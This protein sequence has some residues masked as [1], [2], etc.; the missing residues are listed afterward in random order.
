MVDLLQRPFEERPNALRE[1][2]SPPQ[3]AMSV[4]GD[5]DLVQMHRMG[6]GFRL[7]REDPR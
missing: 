3:T 2:L 1:M 6:S 4:M 5:V 7:D